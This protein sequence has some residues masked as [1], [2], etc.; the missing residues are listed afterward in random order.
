[1]LAA[2]ESGMLPERR[3]H[4]YRK[5]LRENT[6]LAARTDARLRAQQR[7]LFKQRQELGRHQSERKRGPRR[8]A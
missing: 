3:L 4:S 5:L 8:K 6:P 7:K 2:V 1:M